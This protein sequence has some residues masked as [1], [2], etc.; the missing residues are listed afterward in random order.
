[1]GRAIRNAATKISGKEVLA[2]ES[3]A[4]ALDQI[5]T[6]IA[7]NA[8]YDSAYLLSALKAAHAL[9]EG[10]SYGLNMDAG[11]VGCMDDLGI[12]ESY[13]VSSS[14]NCA[15]ISQLNLA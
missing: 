9:Q 13:M 8:G 5:P 3:F 11:A 14:L 7:D 2:M 4:K 10:A 6:I 15:F 1:M 12:T